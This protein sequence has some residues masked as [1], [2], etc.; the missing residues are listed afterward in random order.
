[1]QIRIP[2]RLISLVLTGALSSTL[3][4]A[5][6]QKKEYKVDNKD[7][8]TISNIENDK[9]TLKPQTVTIED[10]TPKEEKT[11]EEKMVEKLELYRYVT[12]TSNVKI[13]SE[14]STKSDKLGILFKG[15]MLPLINEDNGWAEVEYDGKSAYICSDYL[16]LFESYE[17]PF[18]RNI[19]TIESRN[20]LSKYLIK[21]QMIEA[22][23]TV[24][25]RQGPS[26][27][28]PKLDQLKKGD[29]LNFILIYN[30]EWYQVEYNDDV[31][32]VYKDYSKITSN[33]SMDSELVDM[34]FMISKNPMYDID[35]MEEIKNIPKNEV[36]EVYAQYCDYYLAKFNNTIGFV[37]KKHCQ[38][39]GDKYIIIDISSQNL[40]LYIDDKVIIDTPVVTGKDSTPTYCGIFEIYEKGENV[41]WPE[42][43]VT[44][45]HTMAFNRGE[46]IHGAKWRKEFGGQIYKKDG[47]HGCVNVQVEIMG[48]LYELTEL[49]TLVLVKK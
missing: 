32:F 5:K 2:R 20:D 38:S 6:D 23:A 44:V 4:C 9:T 3:A 16:E 8:K 34:M 49:G 13:R 48:E 12:A 31:A 1:M 26:T 45:E 17:Y 7:D 30:D 21:Q 22:T 27:D 41:T 37:E 15:Q 18:D 29:M 39:L 25:V 19:P 40:K 24:N 43:N 28:T 36:I 14:A 33:Y 10:K 35:T 11:I 47:S 42:F 46:E